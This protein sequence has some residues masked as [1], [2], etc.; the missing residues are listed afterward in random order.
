MQEQ[1]SKLGVISWI[2]IAVIVVVVVLALWYISTKEQGIT[3]AS[4]DTSSA[5]TTTINVGGVTIEVPPGSNATVEPVDMP[6]IPTPI[7]NLNRTVIFPSSFSAEAQVIW[8]GKYADIK[9]QLEK[10]PAVYDNWLELGIMWK[11]VDEYQNARDM[12][13]YATR[14][15]PTNPIAF[16]N[17]GFL[18]GYYLHDNVKAEAS[19]KAGLKND[20]QSLFLYQQAF[21][22]YR[23]VLKDKEKARAFA[24]EGARITGNQA[25][26]DQLL[27]TL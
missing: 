5:A 13:E 23:D 10:N 14:L 2:G 26:F 1:K 27:K 20:P 8:K 21:E 19:F 15:N 12:W 24:T 3:G 9:A 6:S 18:Y 11:Q 25:F 22:F 7:P 17:L 4:E 16:G